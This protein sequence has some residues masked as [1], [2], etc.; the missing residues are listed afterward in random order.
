MAGKGF[1]VNYRGH[2]TRARKLLM[3]KGF[4]TAEELALMDTMAVEQAVNAEYEA[5][6][7]GED[8]LLIPKARY[9]DFCELAVWIER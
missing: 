7:S 2:E 5:F 1:E 6:P 8:W 4:R 3:E 9:D